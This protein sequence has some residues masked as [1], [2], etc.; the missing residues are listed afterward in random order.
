MLVVILFRRV[1]DRDLVH[2]HRVK[3]KKL[4]LVQARVQSFHCR[5]SGVGPPHVGINLALMIGRLSNT[6][7]LPF[8]PQILSKLFRKHGICL[9]DGYLTRENS[10]HV[11]LHSWG[12]E[13]IDKREDSIHRI[14]ESVKLIL[15]MSIL[16][17]LVRIRP[18]DLLE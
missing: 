6:K 9:P 16:P 4:R 17:E 11:A 7:W 5:I 8:P 1:V 13:R 10:S 14:N 2:T 3:D 12:R 18:D 15:Q